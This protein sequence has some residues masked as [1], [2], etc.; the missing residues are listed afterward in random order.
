MSIVMVLTAMHLSCTYKPAPVKAPNCAGEAR[1]VVSA[2]CGHF[3]VKLWPHN[4]R[5]VMVAIG[6]R[7]L[8]ANL[9]KYLKRA[10]A[11]ERLTVT[12][13]GRAIVT[14]APAAAPKNLDWVH[15][16]VAEGRAHW[17]GGKPRG[18]R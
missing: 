1:A 10:Q 12:D 9:S 6:V 4:G 11:G 17:G 15:Q 5:R 14:L 8:K 18:L 13:R 7:E 3:A 2:R 16:M